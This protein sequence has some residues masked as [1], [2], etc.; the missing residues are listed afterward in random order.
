MNIQDDMKIKKSVKLLSRLKQST[1]SAIFRLSPPRFRR[2]HYEA[3][4]SPL[5]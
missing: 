5:S 2:L 4:A 3:L 1:V